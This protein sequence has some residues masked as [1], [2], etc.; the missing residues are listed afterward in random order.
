MSVPVVLPCGCDTAA[1]W[2]WV[3]K[4]T[5]L[6]LAGDDDARDFLP[7][8]V[9]HAIGGEGCVTGQEAEMVLQWALH[10]GPHDP[11]ACPYCLKESRAI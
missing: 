1:A 11:N 10:C 5:C 8:V 3:D 9:D 6:A 7:R 2:E 4:E